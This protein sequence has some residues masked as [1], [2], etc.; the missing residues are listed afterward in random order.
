MR[1]T[2]V[3]IVTLVAVAGLA[4]STGAQQRPGGNGPLPGDP[5]YGGAP[6]PPPQPTGYWVTHWGAL[7]TDGPKGLL[8]AANNMASQAEAEASALAQ[9]RSNGGTCK[10][11]TSYFNLCTALVTG[12]KLFNVQTAPTEQEAINKGIAK[13][14]EGNDNNCRVHFSACSLPRF[15]RY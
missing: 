11:E 7:A 6:P 15:V 4:G 1:N 5:G 14:N 13:C 9:C 3:A 2:L 8:G 12:D 10:I